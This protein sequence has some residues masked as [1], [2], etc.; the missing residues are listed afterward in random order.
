M[1]MKFDELS[2]EELI[3]GNQYDPQEKKY[4]CIAC[5]AAFETGEIY[6]FGGRFFDACRAVQMHIRQEHPDRLP[7]FLNSGSKYLSLTDNQKE[8]LE[9]FSEG[10]TDKEI[11]ETLGVSAS[12]VRHQK[13]MFR[14]KAKQAKLYLALYELAL[15]NKVDRDEIIPIHAGAKMVDDR[16]ITTK[17]EQ[18]KILKTAFESLSP[19]KLKAFSPKEKKKVVILKR[20]AEQFEPGRKYTEKQVNGILQSV[21][22]D[23]A[24]LRR[25]L[26]EYGFMERTA[27]CNTYWLK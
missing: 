12:T 7:D 8:L 14:E 2:V 20:I 23:Y 5:G 9:L 17:A 27:D 26:I 24:T 18:D 21:F 10:K 1:S 11:A 13:F 25:Y 15:G 3:S 19:L 6:P 4:I 16:Y 22:D